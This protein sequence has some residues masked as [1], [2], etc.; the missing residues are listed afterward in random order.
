MDWGSG[1]PS[2]RLP[3]ADNLGR[4]WWMDR[5]QEHLDRTEEVKFRDP[6]EQVWLLQECDYR[7]TQPCLNSLVGRKRLSK[8]Q[9]FLVWS[10]TVT[11]LWPPENDALI[12]V[13]WRRELQT[14]E[15]WSFKCT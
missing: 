15:S 14:M 5:Y 2:P 6:H 4:S 12:A 9:I 1:E 8:P 10:V 7:T 3:K 11:V 13:T